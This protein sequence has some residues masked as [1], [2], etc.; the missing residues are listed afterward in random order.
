MSHVE[1]TRA[2][3]MYSGEGQPLGGRAALRSPSLRSGSLRGARPP[4][5]CGREPAMVI[6]AGE[7]RNIV[8]REF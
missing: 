7:N 4:N 5:G 8:K 2:E 1:V 3:R 6:V